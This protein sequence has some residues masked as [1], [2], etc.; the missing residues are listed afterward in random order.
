MLL[1]QSAL[2][3]TPH[4]IFKY[5]MMFSCS[6]MFHIK[7][8]MKW[9]KAKRYFCTILVWKR[10]VSIP[11][12]CILSLPCF[13][14]LYYRMFLYICFSII[15]QKLQ[16]MITC[17]YCTWGLQSIVYRAN[18]QKLLSKKDKVGEDRKYPLVPWIEIWVYCWHDL[19]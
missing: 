4:I 12:F 8:E 15:M 7:K 5:A 6:F 18:Q 14:A 17:T 9:S 16:E 1:T 2:I 10:D 11:N 3:F 19:K 13:Y